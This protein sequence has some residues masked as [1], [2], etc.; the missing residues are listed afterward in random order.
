MKKD[1]FSVNVALLS[2]DDALRGEEI[3]SCISSL[4]NP[5]STRMLLD[6]MSG[7]AVDAMNGYRSVN[8]S[9]MPTTSAIL[10]HGG[11]AVISPNRLDGIEDKMS[12]YGC[13][14]ELSSDISERMNDR[15]ILVSIS[16]EVWSCSIRK[17]LESDVVKTARSL[18][19]V[20]DDDELK[21]ELISQAVSKYGS[22]SD[23]PDDHPYIKKFDAMLFLSGFLTM[24]GPKYVSK[25]SKIS[26]SSFFDVD[27]TR[28]PKLDL[29]NVEDYLVGNIKFD[30]SHYDC[31]AYS[32]SCMM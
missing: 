9:Y 3:S 12:F 18:G 15:P 23:I 26:D 7:L 22:I 2:Y 13:L 4:E 31:V 6:I 11:M 20:A 5:R 24:D 25:L 28:L 19:I 1:H 16:S 10:Y 21:S 30:V 32:P 29:Y 17:S 8:G 27:E 14:S